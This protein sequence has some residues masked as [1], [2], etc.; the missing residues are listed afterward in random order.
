MRLLASTVFCASLLTSIP[1]A[2]ADEARQKLFPAA[3]EIGAVAE[4]HFDDAAAFYKAGNYEAAKVEFSAAYDLSRHPDLLYNLSL[5]AERQARYADALALT[6][7]F[8]AEKGSQAT[9]Q[10]RDEAG[11]RIA[12]LRTQLAPA[13]VTAPGPAPGRVASASAVAPTTPRTTPATEP[14]K[15]RSNWAGPLLLGVG[16]GLVVGGIGC[17]A[18]ALAAQ[19]EASSGG[20]FFAQEYDALLSRGRTLE[21]SAIGLSVVGGV[22]MA[23]GA[24]VMIWQ[25][26]RGKGERNAALLPAAEHSISGHVVDRLR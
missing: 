25:R 6:E 7:R 23:S 5:V 3:P 20:P 8:L 18:G 19:S 11:G 26:V 14:E 15:G 1:A 2:K 17:G 4:R 12:R 22:L 16:G 9:Q 10:E 24:G 13:G 21:R